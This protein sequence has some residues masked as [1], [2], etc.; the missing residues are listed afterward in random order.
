MHGW[1]DSDW[2]MTTPPHNTASLVSIHPF[3]STEA[4]VCS[5]I[6]P[7]GNL[8][9]DA[10]PSSCQPGVA[11]PLSVISLIKRQEAILAQKDACREGLWGRRLTLR[12]AWPT[13]IL[14]QN[15]LQRAHAPTGDKGSDREAQGSLPGSWRALYLH[16]SVVTLYI[17]VYTY[18]CGTLHISN[19]IH[20]CT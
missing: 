19:F 1:H 7:E 3:S 9:P 8:S 5:G 16:M 20:L 13:S 11:K 17:H 10:S 14:E 18:I 15:H 12:K 6:L 4:K 2:T